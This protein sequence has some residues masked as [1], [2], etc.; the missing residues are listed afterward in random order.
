MWMKNGERC[1][2]RWLL[3]G[4]TI[5]IEADGAKTLKII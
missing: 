2:T 5:L 3:K 4:H 1:Y